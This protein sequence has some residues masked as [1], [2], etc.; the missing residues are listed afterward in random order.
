VPG[1]ALLGRPASWETPV[2]EDR[3]EE[4]KA[5]TTDAASPIGHATG[6]RMQRCA[7]CSLCTATIVANRGAWKSFSEGL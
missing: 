7:A 1:T 2:W 5:I 3:K 4:R 6:R